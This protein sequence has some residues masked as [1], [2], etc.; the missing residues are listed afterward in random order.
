MKQKNNKLVKLFMK[1][2]TKT[3][4]RNQQKSLEKHFFVQKIQVEFLEKITDQ[5]MKS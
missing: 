2:A 4:I 3:G 1:Q 5:I